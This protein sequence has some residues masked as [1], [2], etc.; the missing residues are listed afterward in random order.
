MKRLTYS[1]LLDQID[2]TMANAESP[3]IALQAVAFKMFLFVNGGHFRQTA[4]KDRT[5]RALQALERAV[6]LLEPLA[7]AERCSHGHHADDVCFDC[8]LDDMNATA[9]VAGMRDDS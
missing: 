5:R 2:G 6:A 7:E 3:Q 4:S 8:V 9:V 1:Q